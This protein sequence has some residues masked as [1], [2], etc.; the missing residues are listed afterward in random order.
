MAYSYSL[1]TVDGRVVDFESPEQ[2]TR[3]QAEE[4]ARYRI[5][6]EDLQR[7]QL[8]ETASSSRGLGEFITDTGKSLGQGLMD[9]GSGAV[10][11]MQLLGYDPKEATQ[12]RE[13]FESGR[14]ELQASKS[15]KIKAQ[16]QL[17]GETEGFWDTAAFLAQNPMYLADMGVAQVPQLAGV[18]APAGRVAGAVANT[19]TV[20]RA[21]TKVLTKDAA[22]KVIAKA[23]TVGAVAAGGGLNASDVG[24]ETYDRVLEQL[25]ADGVD[26]K[27]ATEQAMSAA[28]EDAAIA[29]TVTLGTSALIPGGTA[30][31]RA[32]IGTPAAK[33]I[34][35][36]VTKQTVPKLGKTKATAIGA[37]GEGGQ[38]FAEESS[39]QLLSNIS[40]IQ[41]GAEGDV[42]EGV[43]KAGATGFM[44][45]AGL[46][47]P[48]NFVNAYQTERAAKKLND[49]LEES[50]QATEAA[51]Q[52]QEAEEA[53]RAARPQVGYDPGYRVTFPDGT[54]SDTVYNEQEAAAE[55]AR[56]LNETQRGQAPQVP[57]TVDRKPAPK[58]PEQP[59]FEQKQKGQAKKGEDSEIDYRGI[60]DSFPD[61]DVPTLKEKGALPKKGK[62]YTEVASRVAN[63]DF[64]SDAGRAEAEA[65]AAE[66]ENVNT[67]WAPKL[68]SEIRAHLAAVK[69]APIVTPVGKGEAEV[70]PVAP[71]D[72]DTKLRLQEKGAALATKGGDI[73][74]SVENV[75]RN[76]GDEG[77]TIFQE[78][79]NEVAK[80]PAP[81]RG[82]SRGEQKA[83]DDESTAGAGLEVAGVKSESGAAEGIKTSE[84]AG[85][86]GRGLSP[87]RDAGR[88]GAISSA[89]DEFDSEIVDKTSQFMVKNVGGG[90]ATA[91]VVREEVAKAVKDAEFEISD[92]NTEGPIVDAKINAA[93]R[94][95]S[96]RLQVAVGTDEE[97]RKIETKPMRVPEAVKTLKGIV[98]PAKVQADIANKIKANK[99]ARQGKRAPLT[100]AD[101]ERLIGAYVA[102][103]LAEDTVTKAVSRLKAELSKPSMLRSRVRA[104]LEQAQRALSDITAIKRDS[105][106]Q[107]GVTKEA[108]Y[109][110]IKSAADRLAQERREKAGE[111]SE[112]AK[113]SRPTMDVLKKRAQ[114]RIEREERAKNIVGPV[115]I[116]LPR[117]PTLLEE[118]GGKMPDK[119]VTT[120][121]PRQYQN[122]I[123]AIEKSKDF[124]VRT[125]RDIEQYNEEDSFGLQITQDQVDQETNEFAREAMA[126][127]LRRKAVKNGEKVLNYVSQADIVSDE[128]VERLTDALE[129][130]QDETATTEEMLDAKDIINEFV[131]EHLDAAEA[132]KSKQTSL[133]ANRMV[134]TPQFD[135]AEELRA[136]LERK[137]DKDALDAG[138]RS[139]RVVLLDSM[140][141]TRLDR[142]TRAAVEAGAEQGAVIGGFVHPNAKG[143]PVVYLVASNIN[144]DET[145]R[146]LVHEA[147]VHAGWR[148]VMGEQSY[149]QAEN[150][151][152]Q[153]IRRVEKQGRPL[154]KTEAVIYEAYR[155][156]KTDYKIAPSEIMEEV[157][158]HVVDQ[159]T[160]I[161]LY[162]RVINSIM[163]WLKGIGFLPKS[164][165]QA[166]AERNVDTILFDLSD[167]AHRA[168]KNWM[169]RDA[170]VNATREG[171]ML[172]AKTG[173]DF[174]QATVESGGVIG[175]PES[176]KTLRDRANKIAYKE[177]D[178][179]MVRK[180]S[181]DYRQSARRWMDE[182]LTKIVSSDA[183]AQREARRR[184][185]D[186]MSDSEAE[187]IGRML[188]I[189]T[190]QTFHAE[191]VAS[192]FLEYGNITYDEKLYKWRAV[193]DDANFA[194]L[195]RAVEAFGKSVGLDPFR[196]QRVLHRYLEMKRLKSLYEDT[197]KQQRRLDELKTENRASSAEYK[198]IK[199]LL[200][201]RKLHVE[202]SKVDALLKNYEGNA[203][204]AKV[205]EIWNKMRKNAVDVMVQGG[206]L[207]EE[208]AETWLDNVDY[209]PFQRVKQIEDKE[210]LPDFISGIKAEYQDK[211]MKGSENEVNDIFDNMA[212]WVEYSVEAAVRNHSGV[213]LMNT[214][215]DLGMAQEV[216]AAHKVDIDEY[217]RGKVEMYMEGKKRTFVAQD[218]LFIEA[219]KGQEGLGIPYLKQAS[220]FTNFLRKSVVLNPIFSLGQLTQDAFGAMFTSGLSPMQA[221]KIPYYVIKEFIKTL[222]G[223]S[224]AHN[225]LKR[226]ASVGTIDYSAAVVVNDIESRLSKSKYKS[227]WKSLLNK[228]E[229]FSM[230]S[231]NAVRQAV[232]NL[233]LADG[234]SQAEAVERSFEI[235]NFRRKGSSPIVHGMARMVPFFNAWLQA[236]N[237]QASTLT[238][239]GI[240]PKNEASRTRLYQNLGMA[241]SMMM[242]YAMMM[243]GDED[244]EELDPM[245]R[246]RMLM[247]PG[248]GGFG[249]PL[250][251][252]LFL[253]PKII[254]E[255]SYRLM[256]DNAMEDGR[257]FRDAL[258]T[259]LV[260]GVASPM[261]VPQILKPMVEVAIDRNFFT[262]RPLVSQA[263]ANLPAYLQQTEYTSELS[264]FIGDASHAVFGGEGLSPIKVDQLIR[265]YFGSVGGAL[266]WTSNLLGDYAGVRPSRSIQDYVASLPG[267][268]RFVNREEGSGMRSYFYEMSRDVNMAYKEYLEL[269]KYR[270]EDL[271]PFLADDENARRVSMAKAVRNLSNRLNKIRAA[272][273]Q[274]SKTSGDSEEKEQMISDLRQLENEILSGM[275]LKEMRAMAGRGDFF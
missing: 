54:V 268:S 208:K 28:R 2:L 178:G 271:D 136:V 131:E 143:E 49:K 174:V 38:E 235:I 273:R 157:L 97:G 251:T 201:E 34:A 122:A 175:E 232:Y 6:E 188:E 173:Q 126:K 55:R 56:W 202:E 24:M 47:A 171:P 96:N 41:A 253:L 144:P 107:K 187:I 3:Q 29:A 269:Q 113:V 103:K 146:V 94:A 105:G 212:K 163:N 128:E 246:D 183:A 15:E 190:S 270:P 138:I 37:L 250:R 57:E 63:L 85:V 185:R 244:Y 133:R 8:E 142:E 151:M 165:K 147:G 274:I 102:E 177:V 155:R 266:L 109:G 44:L 191:G 172:S 106:I 257:T 1:E 71:L 159:H 180:T 42:F 209:V 224:D 134:S 88:A 73:T 215:I 152:R 46:G 170:A 90:G 220:W 254:A 265:G 40:A 272:I 91:Q 217:K 176:P 140:N 118:S 100:P 39:G 262:G 195:M 199:K 164:W 160:D 26:E 104:E 30:I 184:M 248:M 263:Y 139:G 216:T 236:L 10:G 86:G 247:I 267:L 14:E 48:S 50:R 95:V 200:K 78:A 21:L 81:V 65:Y 89:L 117:L 114:A 154:N 219:F 69:A 121:S 218:P 230:A 242:L 181:D 275:N 93:I 108:R 259:A 135:S 5:Y 20:A 225:Y 240:S 233:S 252:D 150:M 27:A 59:S 189:S 51:V 119:R 203:E 129:I 13:A 127:Q 62:R 72:E 115:Y 179:K 80:G 45:G 116:A 243:G 182:K 58:L 161:P 213:R 229:K 31:E 130:Y 145:L 227:G 194:S 149:I 74:A 148:G 25:L 83:A 4:I 79:A 92:L 198:K 210:G 156:V 9:V 68:S 167:I 17:F 18:I 261:A 32:V 53:E 110:Q 35:K 75:R 258:A 137:F 61:F 196:A 87:V 205:V 19:P 193:D 7:K 98:D 221:I 241:T 226:L 36:E 237:V 120:L 132:W 245:Y 222:R 33:Q 256:T 153:A 141:D 123:Y 82:V 16:E 169:L 64:D 101:T 76:Y 231:D 84:T 11:L 168:A 228:L 264:N 162:K 125:T 99:R 211:R 166:I 66:L 22:D 206:L 60:Y 223:T 260:N 192:N 204:A 238:G 43:G 70:K 12:M 124:S 23:G 234:T 77:A 52:K 214:M 186:D 67:K 255:H 239:E 207:T 249:L 112:K 111:Y 158:A 197:R